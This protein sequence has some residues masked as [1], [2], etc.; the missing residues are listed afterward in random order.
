MGENVF[1]IRSRRL[2]D[3]LLQGFDYSF[4]YSFAADVLFAAL[5]RRFDKVWQEVFV[6]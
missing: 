2:P 1:L 6:P 5:I 3:Q 4:L